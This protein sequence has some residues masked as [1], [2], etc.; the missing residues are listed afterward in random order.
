MIPVNHD[1]SV[2]EPSKQCLKIYKLKTL[3]INQNGILKITVQVTKT[4]AE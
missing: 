1:K 3:Q 2:Q 4:K